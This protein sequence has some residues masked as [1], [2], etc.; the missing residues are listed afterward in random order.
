MRVL[1]Q[2]AYVLHVRAWRETSL[3]V[4]AL[5]RDHGRIGLV[6]RGV[7]G[8]KR[9]VLRAALQPLQSLRI[10]YLPRGELARLL[11]AE[12]QDAAPVLAG[13][14]L[15]A[16]FYVNELWLRLTPRN[17]AAPEAFALYGRVRGELAS[18]ESLAWTLRRCERDLLEVLGYGLPLD[19]AADGE[20]VHAASSYRLDPTR[21]PVRDRQRDA[22][23]ISGAALLALA[24]D[25][26]P[27]AELL[28]ELRPA[29]RAVL[30]SHLPGGLKS[31]GLLGELSRLRPRTQD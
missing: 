31:W 25:T 13:D 20:A 26:Q 15:L 16:A 30:A 23:S 7:V 22:G 17:D 2:P 18:G 9:H 27:E 11:Q 10:D 6:A 1:D 14:A 5:T 8:P 28:A 21:G 29:L 12:A 24:T 19:I 3:L 4:E